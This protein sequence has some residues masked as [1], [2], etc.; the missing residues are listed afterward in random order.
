MPL[1]DLTPQD[2]APAD[3]LKLDIAAVGS[4]IT[5]HAADPPQGF[6]QATTALLTLPAKVHTPLKIE[7]VVSASCPVLGLAQ[8][9]QA[10]KVQV[11]IPAAKAGIWTTNLAPLAGNKGQLLVRLVLPKLIQGK[12]CFAFRQA[13]APAAISSINV[14]QVRGSL[15]TL[16]LKQGH[17]AIAYD[18]RHTGA[19]PL[20]V[21]IAKDLALLK[22]LGY[23]VLII[24]GPFNAT[25]QSVFKEAKKVGLKV[26]LG[27]QD[28][29]NAQEVALAL[30]HQADPAAVAY[31]IEHEACYHDIN[32]LLKA[33]PK[34]SD[35]D[36]WKETWSCLTRLQ[37]GM[38]KLRG[39]TTLPVISSQQAN[40]YQPA[41]GGTIPNPTGMPVFLGVGDLVYPVVLGFWHWYGTHKTCDPAK[42]AQTTVDALFYLM[43]YRP[44]ALQVVAKEVGFPSAGSSHATCK[45]DEAAQ[46]DFYTAMAARLARPLVGA[47]LTNP[48]SGNYTPN[49]F[50]Y[51][52]FQGYD[53]HHKKPLCQGG[54]GVEC[55]WGMYTYKKS[56]RQPKQGAVRPGAYLA[57]GSGKV[58]NKGKG[59]IGLLTL[60]VKK[61]AG[62]LSKTPISGFVNLAQPTCYRVVL[63]LRVLGSYYIKP[64]YCGSKDYDVV[65]LSPQGYWS[66]PL[67]TGGTDWSGDR[68]IITLIAPSYA[69]SPSFPPTPGAPGVIDQMIVDR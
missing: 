28:W 60:P 15:A 22:S 29:S 13:G 24:Y 44:G 1:A 19:Y 3:T 56:K 69:P 53:A 20:T 54:A 57:P 16:L 31:D 65:H 41:T 38:H 17:K 45:L 49:P 68:V 18:A 67:E 12:L 63:H 34:A 33:N 55:H 43:K 59:T 46:Q 30:K 39:K 51:V 9:N 21:E 7:A 14:R 42:A 26:V 64:Y 37:R 52:R 8:W 47:S 2:L 66:S 23:G 27:I 10:T 4:K 48:C 50:S 62:P 40:F 61:T 36:R 11:T 5:A 58:V 6:D 25:K 35:A 32:K